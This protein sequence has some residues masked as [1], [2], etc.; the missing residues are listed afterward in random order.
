MF[1]YLKIITK[2]GMM[3][4]KKMDHKTNSINTA[5]LATL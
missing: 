4:I 1:Q 5:C 3:K 2:L